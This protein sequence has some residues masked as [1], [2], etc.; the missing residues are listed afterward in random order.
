M[1]NKLIAVI[2]IVLLCT[3]II[4]NFIYAAE[5]ED[6]EINTEDYKTVQD[7]Y[8]KKSWEKYSEEAKAD[9]KVKAGTKTKELTETLTLGSGIVSTI[10]GVFLI[11]LTLASVFMTKTTRGE[12]ELL[13]KDDKVTAWN[14]NIQADIGKVKGYSINWYTIEDTVFNQISL[15]NTDYFSNENNNSEVNMALKESVAVF[16]YIMKVIAVVIG[17]VMLIYIGIKMAIS[18][19]A[20]ETAKYKE[21][22]KDWLVS[23][24]LIFAMPYIFSF[25]NQIAIALTALFEMGRQ[26]NGFEKSILWQAINLKNIVTGWSYVAII[27]MYGVITVYQI[28]FF[29]MYFNRLLAMGFLI[30]ISPLITITYSATKTKITGTGGKAEGLETLLKEYA[31]NAFLMPLHAA[32]YLVFILSANEIFKVAPFLAVIF[33]AG[34]SRAE[35]IVKNILGMRKRSSIHS[36]AAYMP[37]GK[38]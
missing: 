17:M 31:I 29:L 28:K 33:F 30:V 18:T 5:F 10:G 27:L 12:E 19:V 38:K 4:P 6:L 37:M 36:M 9:I 23:M 16:Y 26:G 1:K 13:I 3:A 14:K 21:M 35:R 24:I 7:A 20:S 32:I 15:F 2:I 25:I 8:G 22:L 11:P 34:L